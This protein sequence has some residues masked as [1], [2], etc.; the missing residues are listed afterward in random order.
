MRSWCRFWDE[1][2]QGHLYT[3]VSLIERIIFPPRFGGLSHNYI[4]IEDKS[5]LYPERFGAG[6]RSVTTDFGSSEGLGIRVSDRS[7]SAQVTL[8]V[9]SPVVVLCMHSALLGGPEQTTLLRFAWAE[10]L[11]DGRLVFLPYDTLLFALP[12]RNRSYLALGGHGPLREAYD[13]VLTIS[14]ESSAESQ[15]F[16]ATKMSGGA[17]ANLE[18]EQVSVSGSLQP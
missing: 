16:T 4:Q 17:A 3:R 13:A 1:R 11:A 14:L 12:Y 2:S 10:G 9:C 5:H 7:W 18:P 8:H 15:A 6:A